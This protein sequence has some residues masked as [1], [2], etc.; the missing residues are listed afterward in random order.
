MIPFFIKNLPG[1][2]V[3]GAGKDSDKI[4]TSMVDGKRNKKS[5]S[6]LVAHVADD[7]HQISGLLRH[8]RNPT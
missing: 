5:R 2:A 6:V 8:A 3:A 4:K 1:C 7:R